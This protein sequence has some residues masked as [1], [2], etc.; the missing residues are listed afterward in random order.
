MFK[1]FKFPKKSKTITTNGGDSKSE[2]FRENAFP[3]V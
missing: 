2:K 1:K 3:E